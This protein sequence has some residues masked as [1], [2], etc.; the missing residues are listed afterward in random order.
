VTGAGAT[1]RRGALA[2]TS[3]LSSALAA[4]SLSLLA[5]F[6][7]GTVQAGV[8][9]PL[10]DGLVCVVHGVLGPEARACGGAAAGESRRWPVQYLGPSRSLPRAFIAV[11]GGGREDRARVAETMDALARF[12][13]N[14]PGVVRLATDR[15][16]LRFEVN[17]VAALPRKNFPWWREPYDPF[18][19]YVPVDQRVDSSADPRV[20]IQALGHAIFQAMVPDLWIARD[21]QPWRGIACMPPLGLIGPCRRLGLGVGP[22]TP[23]IG[24][25]PFLRRAEELHLR[26][27]QL[28]ELLSYDRTPATLEFPTDEQCRDPYERTRVWDLVFV[29]LVMDGWDAA[30]ARYGERPVRFVRDETLAACTLH[31]PSGEG[32]ELPQGLARR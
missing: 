32:C 25:A 6:V 11:P 19:R 10:R 4:A 5:M 20:A 27:G 2:D 28:C 31:N 13:E 30:V 9:P 3:G 1:R 21:T 23:V 18:W 7:A 15:S 29:K 14:A 16:L 26:I 12:N 17:P 24:D 22:R 8:L